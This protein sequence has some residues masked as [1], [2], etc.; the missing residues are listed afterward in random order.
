MLDRPFGEI[1][2]LHCAALASKRLTF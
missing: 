2:P 1:E